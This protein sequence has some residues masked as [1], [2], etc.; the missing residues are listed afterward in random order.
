MAD[1]TTPSAK[2]L[3]RA[4]LFG[5]ECR[6]RKTYGCSPLASKIWLAYAR[7]TGRRCPPVAEMLDKAIALG[8]RALDNLHG[9]QIRVRELTYGQRI[10]R[11][12][13]AREARGDRPFMRMRQAG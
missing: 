5:E 9:E 7:A 1:T 12:A 4:A 2:R 10:V 6:I 3:T 13:V 8:R 11:E